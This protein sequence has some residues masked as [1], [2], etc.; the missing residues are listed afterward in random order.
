VR[1]GKQLGRERAH[2]DAGGGRAEDE[3]READR[4]GAARAVVVDR[5]PERDEREEEGA[6]APPAD[7]IAEPAG[8]DVADDPDAAAEITMSE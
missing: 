1:R 6:D 2:D 8:D 5:G 7:P 4:Q 3:A